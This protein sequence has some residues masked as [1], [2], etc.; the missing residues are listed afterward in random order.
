MSKINLSKTRNIGI[1]AHIDAGKTTTTERILF[2]TGTNRKMGEVHDGEATMD[3]MKQE[4]ERGITIASAA[5]SCSW[6]DF[7]INI[8]DTPGHVDFTME[9]ERSL[10]VLDGMVALFCAVSGVEP[11][12]ETVW[13]QADEHKVPRLAFINKMDRQGADFKMVLQMMKDNLG[14]V[15]VP[16]QYPIGKE[17]NFSGI[18]DLVSEK[19]YKF[20]ELEQTEIPIPADLVDEVTFYRTV[21]IEA[22]AEFDD[23]LMEIFLEDGP[24]DRALLMAAARK[25]VMSG[26]IT[27]VFCGSAFKNKGVRLLLNAVCDYL[28]SPEDITEIEAQDPDTDEPITIKTGTDQPFSALAFKIIHDKYVGEQ[29]FCRI[30]AGQLRASDAVLNANSGKKEKVGRIFKIHAKDREEV[31]VAYAGDIVAMIG[32]KTTKTGHTLCSLDH[33]VMLESIKSPETVISVA[34]SIKTKAEQDKLSRAL[35]KLAAEDPSF[36]VKIDDETGETIISGMGELHLEVI[37]DRLQHEFQVVAEVGEPSV[38]FRE[39]ITGSFQHD[40]RY[41][42]QSG[43]RGQYAH[44]IMK[45][46]PNEAGGFIFVNGIKG[47]TIPKEYIGPIEQSIIKTM[48]GGVYADYPVV[49]VQ[50]TLVDGS[51]HEVDSSEQ[52]FRT[53]ASICFK[54]AFRK[55]SPQ[56]LEPMMKVDIITPESHIG[57]VVA[58]INRRRGKINEMNAF[59]QNLHKVSADVPLKEMFGYA[60][61]LR[62]IS[63][64]RANFSMEFSCYLPVPK[65]IGE[66]IMAEKQKNK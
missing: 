42:K 18:I 7:S 27:A 3:F 62:T 12:S 1:A 49:N 51:F 55:A 34:I 15:A 63:S 56:L 17:E 25:A 19:A 30:Y 16:F 46:E 57:D 41:V 14:A 20:T 40:Y 48:E 45:V 6:N 44:T 43:G 24:I 8:I 37:V 21:L 33:P 58:D 35:H 31:K 11:Q 64:G 28:P 32:L 2:F 66:A 50:V 26:K 52:A 5:I 60:S 29:I 53:C 59:K 65:N 13:N 39:T 54:E 61:S 9:V 36:R 47:G 4:Q 38:S 22:V 10:R 23:K